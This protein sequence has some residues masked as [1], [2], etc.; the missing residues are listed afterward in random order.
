LICYYLSRF[1]RLIGA[2]DDKKTKEAFHQMLRPPIQS[3][4]LLGATIDLAAAGLY[5]AAALFP[6]QQSPPE[7]SICRDKDRLVRTTLYTGNNIY[8]HRSPW[9]DDAE[10]E[11]FT[12]PPKDTRQKKH[13]TTFSFAHAVTASTPNGP[14]HLD[15]RA[16]F[17]TFGC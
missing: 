15:N 2:G 9:P 6:S 7:E 17:S 12:G 14:T 8:L 13:E 5:T 10:D 11:A 1:A 3:L 16:P 4:G